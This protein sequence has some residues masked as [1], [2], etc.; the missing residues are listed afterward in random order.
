MAFKMKGFPMM[1]TSALKKHDN[2]PTDHP[3]LQPSEHKDTE[4]TRGEG[5]EDIHAGALVVHVR[6]VYP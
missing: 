4:I 2:P 1:K 5:Y 3:P 6:E